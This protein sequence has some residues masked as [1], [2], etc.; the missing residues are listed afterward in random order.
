MK[1]LIIIKEYSNGATEYV[2]TEE[3]WFNSQWENGFL[4]AFR[5]IAKSDYGLRHVCLAVRTSGPLSICLSLFTQ[6][7]SDLMGFYEI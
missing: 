5:K 4:G 7:G 1:L 2:T 3:L 6:L